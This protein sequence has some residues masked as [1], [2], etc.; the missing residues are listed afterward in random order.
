MHSPCGPPQ[1]DQQ[2]WSQFDFS[3][4]H[5]DGLVLDDASAAVA[6]LAQR[7]FNSAEWRQSFQ[8]TLPAIQAQML[9]HFQERVRALQADLDALSKTFAER[10]AQIQGQITALQERIQSAA[11]IPPVKAEADTFLAAI[12]VSSADARLGLPGL[13]MRLINPREPE[14]SLIETVTDLDG[15]AIFSLSNQAVEELVRGEVE[16]TLEVLSPAGNPLQR[17]ERG[18]CPRPNQT[19]TK[20]VL[21][22]N[23][24][25]LESPR[26]A[27]L[28][29]K[30]E[31][32]ERLK[33]LFA[34]VDRLKLDRE[35]VQKVIN[36]RLEENQKIIA[37][38]EKGTP[39]T[40]Q[41]AVQRAGK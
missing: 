19:E 18:L 1:F 39:S 32:D 7:L 38:L 27:A 40:E 13:V 6:D 8:G 9:N 24:P 29:T 22:E 33:N 10:T 5:L 31:R 23:S 36:C 11:S 34:K 4:W 25:E 15:N 28:R 2:D 26:A 17:L 12:K 35:A 37:E 21:L 16:P 3:R 30:T 14:K 41:P 20:V